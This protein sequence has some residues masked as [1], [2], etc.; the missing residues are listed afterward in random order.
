MGILNLTPD[1]FYDGGY[2]LDPEQAVRKALELEEEGAD[3]IAIGGESS[4]PG[5]GEVAVSTELKRVLPVLEKLIPRL[6]VPVSIDTRKAEVA[7]RALEM[8]AQ[9]INDI[10]AL[11]FDPGMIE[12]AAGFS[13]PLVVMHMRGTPRDM[14]RAPRY[15][16]V[17]GEMKEFFHRR[18]E[19]LEENGIRRE[20]VILDP[21]IGFGK[22]L[23]HNLEII[24]GLPRLSDLTRPILVGPSRK[25]FIG[26]I[27]GLPV[28]E[29]LWGTA[30]AVAALISQG[31]HIIRVH[32]PREIKEVAA[33]A[34]R[35]VAKME[36]ISC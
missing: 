4:R 17:I 23:E 2:Y 15:R 20:R 33:I 14:Q 10:T 12:V 35:I 25:S 30:A 8:G 1:S 5:A 18:L 6:Q 22:T 31:A 7:R 19:W 26:A 28:T 9:V 32:D 11:R 27:T 24:A 21:G 36:E 16:D 34:D 29:R 3:I 13:G